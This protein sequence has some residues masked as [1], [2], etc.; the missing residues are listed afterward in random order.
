VKVVG[1]GISA[2]LFKDKMMGMGL[3]E[4]KVFGLL[5]D[6]KKRGYLKSE[7]GL[8]VT[9]RKGSLISRRK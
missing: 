5:G 8:F 2:N 7:K 9:T 6:L 4:R 3:D 1:V